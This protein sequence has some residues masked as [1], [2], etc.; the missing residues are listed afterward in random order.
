MQ[1]ETNMFPLLSAWWNRT[2]LQFRTAHHRKLGPNP[3]LCM[4]GRLHFKFFFQFRNFW[5]GFLGCL[6]RKTGLHI[7]KVCVHSLPCK[8]ISNVWNDWCKVITIGLHIIDYT[9]AR[10]SY[11]NVINYYKTNVLFKYMWHKNLFMY[12]MYTKRTYILNN[13]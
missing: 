7:L 5:S 12:L 2:G 11:H 1:A 3:L 13:W 8:T 9:L 6:D 4:L 10:S